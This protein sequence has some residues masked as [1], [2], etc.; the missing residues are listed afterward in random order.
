MKKNTIS[1][2]INQL[3]RYKA[4]GYDFKR[5]YFALSV[6]LFSILAVYL[7]LWLVRNLFAYL[8]RITLDN[9]KTA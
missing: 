1:Q 8:V 3:H 7:I 6:R 5:Y 9:N 2:L 4:C